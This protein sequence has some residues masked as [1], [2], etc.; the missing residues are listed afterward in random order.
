M[1]Q[2]VYISIL[3]LFLNLMLFLQPLAAGEKEIIDQAA[4]HYKNG[5]YYNTITEAK[6]YQ[7]FYPRGSFYSRSMV[8]EGKA[9][10]D[11]DNYGMASHVLMNCYRNHTSEPSGDEA[12][13]LLG[14]M[15]LMKGP[16]MY[17]LRTFQ[18]YNYIYMNGKYREE[19]ALNNCYAL[20][21]S[22]R[23]EDAAREIEQYRLKYPGGKYLSDAAKLEKQVLAEM[24]RPRKSVYVSVLGSLFIPGFGHFYTGNYANGFFSLFTNALLIYL[25]YDG[26][27][28][29][30]KF[31]MIFFTLVELSFYQYSV[32]GAISDVHQYNNRAAFSREVRLGIRGKW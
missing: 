32:Y 6:R 5:E 13:Y 2:I 30:D 25:I 12:L 11:G 9:Y 28:K 26:Y 27:Q 31:Q 22:S 4:L 3:N 8:L 24:E 15:R 23:L 20:A 18:E 1:K 14:S 21:L 10:F 29:D 19:A 16:P 7:Y 17:A